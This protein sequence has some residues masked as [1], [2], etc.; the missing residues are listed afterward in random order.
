MKE[1]SSMK[2]LIALLLVA[3][4]AFGMVA[5]AESAE[6]PSALVLTMDNMKCV[7]TQKGLENT[8]ELKD[9]SVMMALNTVPALTLT[10]GAY[11]GEDALAFAV[12]KLADSKVQV[13]INGVDK[14]FEQDYPQQ[15]GDTTVV[16]N[17]IRN[18]LPSM[19][20]NQLPLINAVEVPKM[21]LTSLVSA[22]STGE[23]EEN[24]AKV[25]SFTIPEMIIS[26]LVS[27]AAD[28]ANSATEQAPQMQMLADLLDSFEESGMGIS[29]DGK[30]TDTAAE[31][32]C[33]IG[34]M[35]SANGQK[36]EAPTVV[37]T[38]TSAQNNFSLNLAAPNGD[39]MYTLGD[40]KFVSDPAKNTMDLNADIMGMLTSTVSFDQADGVQH[41]QSTDEF[42]GT[43]IKCNVE[44]GRDKDG[45]D[46]SNAVLEMG[47][48]RYSVTNTATTD[49]QGSTNGT[50]T[51]E[52]ENSTQ[53]TVFSADLH[54]TLGEYDSG[55]QM[56]TQT[57]PLSELDSA[58]VQEA[59]KPLMDYI[60]SV[61]TPEAA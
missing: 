52:I 17:M 10:T 14:T 32:T 40:I 37:L 30:L 29:L 13:A 48:N 47:E 16:A 49:E 35:I 7:T 57:A 55:F 1:D 38:A 6:G 50:T 26:M 36:A 43:T 18:L 8:T 46:Y 33:E 41:I 34:V 5:V 61:V 25:T 22:F 56:P 45:V 53:K 59:L 31:Q 58:Q 39:G 60:S 12:M 9:L 11:V 24:G 4:M 20:S 27:Q 3:M 21:D 23:T 2:K 54:E 19:A 28:M 42:L 15:V 44:Y 51:V